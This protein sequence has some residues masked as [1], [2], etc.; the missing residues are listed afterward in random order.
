TLHSTM[1][2]SATGFETFQGVSAES[3]T[4]GDRHTVT[5]VSMD[6]YVSSTAINARSGQDA[7]NVLLTWS[8]DLFDRAT[9]EWL[10][11]RFVAVLHDWRADGASPAR[12]LPLAEEGAKCELLRIGPG[13]D[14]AGG[15]AR[16]GRIEQAAT[17]PP[18]AVALVSGTE[19]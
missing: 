9:A 19:K 18:D 17:A 8:A 7:M 1:D 10:V 12:A 3:F 16:L 11:D 2:V 14:V 6:V 4:E 13:P 15:P 5:D